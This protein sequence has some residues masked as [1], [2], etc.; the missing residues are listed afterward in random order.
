MSSSRSSG[1]A[2]LRAARWVG[3]GLLDQLVMA[4][5]NAANTLL[6]PIL[7]DLGRSGLM[8]LALGVGYFAMYLN[9]AFVG[10]VL[11]ALASRHDGD[12]R[13]RLVR[14][15]LGTA[16]VS[17]LV[18]C[19]IFVVIWLSWPRGGDT[20]LRDLIWIAPFLPFIMLHDTARC[21]YLADRKPEKALTID[22]VWA[23]T[24]GVLVLAVVLAGIRSPAA[25]LASW[26]CGAVAGSTVFLVREK[27]RP[28]Q[29]DLRQW[30]AETRHLS[31][32]FTATAIV[33]QLQ[34]QA[35]TFLVAIRLSKVEVAGL[36]FV[37]TIQVQ[38]V[39]NLI[40]A[41]SGLLVPRASRHASAAALPGPEGD[42]A[43]AALRRQTR[44][45]ALAFGA[46]GV[47]M[48]LC[49]WPVVSFGLSHSHKFHDFA[50]LAL[51]I[52]LQGAVYLLQVPFTAAMRGMHRAKLLFLQYVAFSVV[53]LTGLVV[54]AD[55]GGLL[56]A[57]WGLFAG[58]V[59]G[60]LCMIAMYWYALRWLRDAEPAIVSSPADEPAQVT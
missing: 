4:A 58:S 34:V 46:L 32:W 52:A 11:I 60:L 54:G 18:S 48:V 9:R 33:G 47:V 55:R 21:T 49:V 44:V 36:R 10:D 20:D 26:G 57:V 6:G 24:Q 27:Q 5:A 59:V 39:Q 22:L 30:F 14:N 15:G 37:Q 1:L 42:A 43:G 31:G 29:G 38:P 8:V 13:D 35:V 17:G 50:P 19:L 28:W 40:T 7:L 45:L 2:K 3:A 25:L 23:G 12:H 41:I 51:P 56:G 53:S 16:A